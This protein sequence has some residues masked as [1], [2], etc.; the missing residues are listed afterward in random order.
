VLVRDGVVVAAG[1][2]ATTPVPAGYEK[3]DASG[4]TLV[5][6]VKGLPVGG[7]PDVHTLDEAA[8]EILSGGR[9]FTGTIEP[10]S[11][12]DMLLL[13]GNPMDDPRSLLRIHRVM[14]GGEWADR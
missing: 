3:I 10:G 4:R 12:A 2:R 11:T 14:R 5:P 7:T 6:P 8:R 13:N 1:A 9:P